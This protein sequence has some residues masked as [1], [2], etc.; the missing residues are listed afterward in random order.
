M[1]EAGIDLL[2]KTLPTFANT[3]FILTPQNEANATYQPRGYP[4]GGQINPY[5][6]E[7]KN[8]R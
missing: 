2:K 7:E 3:S 6:P 4:Y 5:W 8:K 1:T